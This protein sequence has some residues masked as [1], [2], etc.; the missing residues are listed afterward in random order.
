MNL[1]QQILSTLIGS[2]FGF[3][4][5]MLLF[6]FQQTRTTQK[7]H[8]F[9]SGGLHHEIEF[10]ASVIDKWLK[11]IEARRKWLTRSKDKTYF[12]LRYFSDTL[13]THFLKKSIEEG[14]LY[15]RINKGDISIIFDFLL[16][17]NSHT[18]DKINAMMN[19]IFQHRQSGL[20]DS[21]P[22]KIPNFELELDLEES[23]LKMMKDVLTSVDMTKRSRQ[24]YTKEDLKTLLNDTRNLF[25]G[26]CNRNHR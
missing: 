9:I 3:L 12:P 20:I 4:F 2:F 15:S 23:Q 8:E 13:Q 26:L 24:H 18:E 19:D 22:T 21:Y 1:I 17:K 25:A 10:N 14:V 5:G 6:R 7:N 16:I 11:E